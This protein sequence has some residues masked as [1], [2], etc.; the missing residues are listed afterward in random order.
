ML[1]QPSYS[2]FTHSVGYHTAGHTLPDKL[3]AVAQ[4]GMDGIE[5]F[6]DDLWTFAQSELFT[7]LSR[8][9]EL[10]TPPDSP[11]AKHACV[12]K[13]RVWNA[14]GEC[15]QQE[16][17]REV[18][19]AKWVKARCDE[20]GL[21]VYCLQ[22]LR[23]VEGWVEEEKRAE[24]MKRVESR[25]AV[26]QALD[27]QLLLVCSQNTPAP[28]TTGDLEALKRD[29]TQI[30]NMA[31]R[32]T[33]RTGHEV[34]VGFEALAW[35]S[36]VDKWTQAWQVVKSVDRKEVGLILDG[37]NTLAREYADPCSSTGIQEPAAQT[38]LRLGESLDGIVEVPGDKIFLLQIGDAKKLPTPL[39]PSPREGEERP[40]RMIWSRSSRLFPCEYDQGAFMPVPAFV[41]RV[42]KAGYKGP[43]SI[44]V[45]NDSLNDTSRH[46]T[47]SHA[48]R[49]RAGLDRLVEHVFK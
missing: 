31:E 32:F 40:S 29:F 5:L 28:A 22:P 42:V 4:A 15:T 9:G 30:A 35:G 7:T 41:D 48:T 49:A 12:G 2:I 34:R 46:T 24:A 36:H 38:L 37:F 10:L 47:R 14:Y 18:E 43:W 3:E 25:F 6:T 26:M 16:A 33:L 45:F 17:E 8:G 13:Q 27:T 20:L 44:E 1:A 23:D 19:A 21:K 39:L 11:L